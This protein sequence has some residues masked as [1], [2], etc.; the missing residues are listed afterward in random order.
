MMLDPSNGSNLE[1]LALKGLNLQLMYYVSMFF[2]WTAVIFVQILTA[3]C[4]LSVSKQCIEF[5]C[6]RFHH[7]AACCHFD[8]LADSGPSFSAL[9]PCHFEF[10]V[11]KFLKTKVQHTDSGQ[12]WKFGDL[13]CY[14]F[15]DVLV[16][17]L[18]LVIDSVHSFSLL[19]RL[20]SLKS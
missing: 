11:W 20:L 14:I 15:Y 12:S 10:Q 19:T 9:T 7:C 5:D 6:A 17:I 13:T 18:F 4:K 16:H 3:V 1:Q 2:C 8:A